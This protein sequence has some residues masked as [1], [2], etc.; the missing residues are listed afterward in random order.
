MRGL[1]GL[2]VSAAVTMAGVSAVFTLLAELEERYG[3]STSGLGLIAGSAFLAALVAQLWLA[4]FADRATTA[5]DQLDH[6]RKMAADMLLGSPVRDAYDLEQ[7]D[8]RVRAMYGD[9]IC[10]QSL[11]LARRLVE[12][13]VRCVEITLGGWDTHANN[14]EL[15]AGRIDILDPAFAAI[16]RDLKPLTPGNFGYSV[17]RASV[18]SDRFS[19]LMDYARALDCDLEGLHC[20]TGPGVWEGALKSKANAEAADRANLFKTFSKVFFQ[21]QDLMAT[22]MA[23]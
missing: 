13:G 21:K 16:I 2:Y 6:F 7:E 19:G 4:R 11:L 10:G 20:E 8:P 22:F 17:L 3:L 12:A 9:H 23:K 1:R 18:E 5:Y 14:H 15:Q